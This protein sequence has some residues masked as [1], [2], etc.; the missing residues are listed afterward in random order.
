MVHGICFLAPLVKIILFFSAPVLYFL[1]GESSG[2]MDFGLGALGS[3]YLM[4]AW[5]EISS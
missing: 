5:A 1:E 3:T 2:V 4:R